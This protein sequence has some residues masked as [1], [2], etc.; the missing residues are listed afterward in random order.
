MTGDGGGDIGFIKLGAEVDPVVRETKTV[1]R[2]INYL[3][4]QT[5]QAIPG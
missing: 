2:T 4:S 5:H 3:D 1:T